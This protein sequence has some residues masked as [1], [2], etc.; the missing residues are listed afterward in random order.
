MTNTPP[1]IITKGESH[2]R[3]GIVNLLHV[4]MTIG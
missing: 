4:N 1:S 2:D 3:V